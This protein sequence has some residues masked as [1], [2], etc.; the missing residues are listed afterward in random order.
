MSAAHAEVPR[1]APRRLV[2]RRTA[3][4]NHGRPGGATSPRVRAKGGQRV[5]S[6]RE[7]AADRHRMQ[8][9]NPVHGDRAS[10]GLAHRR[11]TVSRAA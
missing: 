10:N 7:G 9:S 8:V 5:M 2:T 1:S 11:P 3:S 4:G 6:V